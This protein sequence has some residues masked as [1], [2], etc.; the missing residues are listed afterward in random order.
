MDILDLGGNIELSGFSGLQP[1]E[2]D[3]VKKIVGNHAKRIS[4]VCTNFEKLSIYM[5][6]VHST[7]ASKKFEIHAKLLDNGKHS[8]TEVVDRSIFAGI[9]SALTKIS[10][11][12]H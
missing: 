2:L 12:V 11:I 1:A 7:E 6:T 9:D 8:T 3:V 4:D 5:K 10:K